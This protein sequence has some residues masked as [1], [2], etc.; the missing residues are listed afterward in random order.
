MSSTQEPDLREKDHGWLPESLEKATSE[1]DMDLTESSFFH[2]GINR[3]LPTVSTIDATHQS[4][5]VVS[6]MRLLI[7]FG[8]HV[9]IAEA[10]I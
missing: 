8:P 1:K 9:I 5:L 3:K 2:V 4:I 10:V 7:K 6:E